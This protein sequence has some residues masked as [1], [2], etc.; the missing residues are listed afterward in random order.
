MNGHQTLT[1]PLADRDAQPRCAVRVGVQAV[2]IQP[3][4]F[5]A[6][7]PAPPRDEQGSPLVG[8]AQRPD[9]RHQAG[10]LVGGDEAGTRLGRLGR[11]RAP[12]RGRH[13][14][15]GQPQ[16]V[17]SWK[18]TERSDRRVSRDSML[19]GR[20]VRGDTPR[21]SQAAYAR[22]CSRV[23]WAKDSTA[24]CSRTSQAMNWRTLARS[25]MIVAG[26]VDCASRTRRYP[27]EEVLH[28]WPWAGMRKAYSRPC[29]RPHDAALMV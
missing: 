27:L 1:L 23:T 21:S 5:A 13:D 12:S 8:A 28:Q 25:L 19:R 11:S 20:R 22:T 9:R 4:H 17:V 7:G 14:A 6:A 3:L 15:C 10:E 18:K 16:A 2:Q 26:R 24:G 29:G